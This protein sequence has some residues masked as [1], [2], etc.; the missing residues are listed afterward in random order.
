MVAASQKPVCPVCNKSDKVMK[1]QTAFNEGIERFA[2]PPMPTKR[3]SMIGYMAF[4]MFIVGICL[5]FIFILVG[6]ESFGTGF[7]IA[8]LILVILTLGC[9][10]T[11]LVLSYIA[12][13]KAVRGD[14]EVSKQY[15]EWDRA[16]ERYNRLR[17]CARDNVVFDA[18]TRKIISEEELAS[19]LS[20]EV[21]QEQEKS[22]AQTSSA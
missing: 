19:L 9:I 2:P 20:T 21:K 10:V 22:Q 17:Y 4:G 7:S 12:F 13:T 5:F 1:L 15:P 11:A 14:L 8:E 18:E 3:V 16:M 6:S